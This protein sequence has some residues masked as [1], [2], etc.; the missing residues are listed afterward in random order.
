MAGA[1]LWEWPTV[2]SLDAPLIAVLWQA[3]FAHTF[4]T[5]LEWQHVF[6]LAA[7][8]WL[9]YSADRLFDGL[10]QRPAPTRRHH[11]YIVYRWEVASVWCVVFILGLT[12]ALLTLHT[13]ELL[14]GLLVLGATLAYFA[15]VHLF[16]A[17]LNVSKEVQVALLFGAGVALFVLPKLVAFWHLFVPLTL[18]IVLCAL[19]CA[20]ISQWEELDAHLAGSLLQRL[21]AR[22]PQ[23]A[24]GLACLAALLILISPNTTLLYA[25]IAGS[26][27]ALFEL[28]RSPLTPATLRVL[29]DA[30]LLTPAPILFTFWLVGLW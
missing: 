14:G 7:P 1:K 28:N 30:A 2:L 18:F 20:F 17:T 3:L 26:S 16:P 10:S 15:R 22:L 21:T 23:S 4:G 27:F 19:N 25:A 5:T 8:V 6:L 11:F 12:A 13:S 29:G 24:L 9:V